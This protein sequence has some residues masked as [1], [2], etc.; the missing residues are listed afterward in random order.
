MYGHWLLMAMKVCEKYLSQFIVVDLCNFKVHDK[1]INKNNNGRIQ[2][3][4]IVNPNKVGYAISLFDTK[5]LLEIDIE[6]LYVF[7]IVS[8]IDTCI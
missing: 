6:T 5:E 4:K 2:G 3:K 1:K 7:V 8:N